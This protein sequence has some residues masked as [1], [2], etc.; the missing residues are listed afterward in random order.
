M[1]IAVFVL[2]LF[3]ASPFYA[4][5]QH[6][7][8][9]RYISP[10]SAYSKEW[11]N[12]KYKVCN[13]AARASYMTEDEKRVIY[14]LNLARMNPKLFCKTVVKKAYTIVSNLDTTST[15]YYKSLVAEMDTMQPLKLLEPDSLCFESA[16][17]HAI[18][19]G[20]TGYTGHVR[21]NNAS[22]KVMH[23]MGECCDYG[24]SDPLNIVITL[25]ID[26]DVESLGHRSIC[27]GYFSKIG[28]SIQPHK[29]YQ[30]IAVLDFYHYYKYNY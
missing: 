20:K 3:T 6:T 11:D 12:P 2:L 22:Q 30:Y 28:D 1:K 9:S 4:L 23:F 19:S 26:Q 25:L 17:G 27:F 15:Q 7:S 21:Q 13:T 8:G 10:L 29:T 14:I 18:A 24:S 16:K 5:S